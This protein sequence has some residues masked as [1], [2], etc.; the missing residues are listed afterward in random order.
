MKRVVLDSGVVL[1]FLEGKHRQYYEKILKGEVKPYVNAVNLAEVYY[2]LCRK[3]GTEKAE[4]IVRMIIKSGFEV[5]GVNPLVTKY[6]SECKCRNSISMADCLSI[7]TAK[8]LKTTA[9]F[10]REKELEGKGI[11]EVEFVD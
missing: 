6:A 9:L 2:V 10:R 5:V 7:A 1:S 8:Y 4:K 11:D 3:V